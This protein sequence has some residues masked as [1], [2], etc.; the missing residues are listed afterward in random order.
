MDLSFENKNLKRS[1]D[2]MELKHK[3][4]SYAAFMAVMMALFISYV[5]VPQWERIGVLRQELTVEKIQVSAVESYIEKNPDLDRQ[6]TEV[7]Q[8]IDQT[9][10]LLPEQNEI[11][12]F[13]VQLEQIAKASKI[14]LGQVQ[15]DKAVNR[16]GYYE[17]PIT[18]A[19]RGNYF[20]M[21]DFIGRLEGMQRFI[22]VSSVALMPQAGD[23][24]DGKIAA[25]LYVYGT[26]VPQPEAG[27]KL[28]DGGQRQ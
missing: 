8:K 23:L 5:I 25:V 24:L 20:Q 2:T 27:G 10:L 13:L 28:P 12:L 19:V 16:T 14:T 6:I 17:V 26:A 11:G 18:I 15:P 7:R 3:V 4:A 22:S 9:R 1:W 21:L